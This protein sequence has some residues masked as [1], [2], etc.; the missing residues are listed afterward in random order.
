MEFR[1][2]PFRSR[3]RLACVSWRTPIRPC[4]P[5]CRF[6]AVH[7]GTVAA[8]NH[9]FRS[10]SSPTAIIAGLHAL[11]P[12]MTTPASPAS[13]PRVGFVSLAC[14][15]ALVDSERI[16]TQLKV[17]G[18]DIVQTYRSE[19]HKSEPQSLMTHTYAVF[20]SQKQTTTYPV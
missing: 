14:P 18:Y 2:W 6:R 11:Q 3:G 19:E 10:D 8:L 17:E 4:V 13:N 16:L 15:K 12:P 7:H 1:R 5:G 20:G 9:H